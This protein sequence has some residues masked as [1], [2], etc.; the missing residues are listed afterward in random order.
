[1]KYLQKQQPQSPLLKQPNPTLDYWRD[2]A[3]PRRIEEKF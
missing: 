1:M 3:A 2:M